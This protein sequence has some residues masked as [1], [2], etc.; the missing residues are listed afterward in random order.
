MDLVQLNEDRKGENVIS[1]ECVCLF[2]FSV[3]NSSF[4]Q[5]VFWRCFIGFPWALNQKWSN[6]FRRTDLPLLMDISVLYWL[7]IGLVP[8]SV[9]KQ[10]A[11]TK[12]LE[13]ILWVL[14]R[15]FNVTKPYLY[16][17]VAWKAIQGGFA[18]TYLADCSC[19]ICSESC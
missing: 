10:V 2:V 1:H 17:T 3:I 6:D 19:V 4:L 18:S 7:P 16:N 15:L 11:S 8:L 9:L 5:L 12:L 14:Y 13:S